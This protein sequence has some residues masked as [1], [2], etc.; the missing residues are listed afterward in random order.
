[1]M[2]GR[3]MPTE[4]IVELRKAYTELLKENE[5]L[6]QNP[7]ERYRDINE[8]QA[9]NTELISRLVWLDGYCLWC[10]T[11]MKNG[12]DP[13]CQRQAALAKEER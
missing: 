4:S 5:R 11:Y 3:V 1:M 7:G 8:L 13:D 9:A 12:H 10:D 2:D 6:R